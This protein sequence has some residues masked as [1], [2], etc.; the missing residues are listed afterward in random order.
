[1]KLADQLERLQALDSSRSFIVQAPAGSG[2]TEL[3]IQRFL[4]LLATVEKS[5]EEII[6]ITFTRKAASEM[7]ARVIT[8]LVGAE[9][10][11]ELKSEHERLTADL[12]Q[13]ALAQ[14]RRL[15]WNIIANPN[16]LRIQTIDSLCARLVSQMPILSQLTGGLVISDD[17]LALY[18]KAVRATLQSLDD[19]EFWSSALEQILLYLNNDFV[20]AER[21]LIDMLQRRDQWL[22]HIFGN[23]PREALEHALQDSIKE[24]LQKL[25]ICFSKME[26]NQELF[27]LLRF[28]ANNL[29]QTNP[30][31]AL[32]S[33]CD[34]VTFPALDADCL[35][36]WQAIANFLLTQSG[37]FRLKLTVKEGFPA[38]STAASEAD[39]S[40]FQNMK[41]RMQR[42]LEQCTEHEVLREELINTLDLPPAHYS[43]QQWQLISALVKLLPVLTAQ[44][45]L[46]FK[47]HKTVDH[48]EIALRALEA[49][50]HYDMPSDLALALDYQ[51]SHILI[52]EFQDTSLTQFRL[53]EKLT[54]GWEPYDQRT[55]FL[56]GDP[57][58][59]I[60][61][62]RKAE[63]GLF[64]QVQKIGVG[65]KKCDFLQL[66]VNFRSQD[67]IINWI[68]AS[69]KHI[70]P[71]QSNVATGAIHYS[72]SESFKNDE[73]IEA[74]V[75]IHPLLNP[76]EGAEANLV[77]KLIQNRL[78]SK[79][80]EKIAIL[81]QARSHLIEIIAALQ[82][83]NISY[84]AVEIDSLATSPICQDLL[85]LTRALTHLADRIAWLAILRAPWCGLTLADLL[86]IAV[87]PDD[88][89]IYDQLLQYE[90]L[91]LSAEGQSRLRKFMP[92]IKNS[93]QQ[94]QR[95]LLHQWLEATW[96]GLGGPACLI[97]EKE[98]INAEAFFNLLADCEQ[99]TGGVDINELTRRL[100]NLTAD[101][102]AI[103]DNP[104]EIMTIH[105]S[106]GLEFDTVIL[107]S[108]EKQTRSDSHQ[109]LLWQERTTLESEK[110]LIL[111]PIKNAQAE[112]IYDY[113]RKQE[114][115][116]ARH[117][118]ARLLYVAVTR[119]KNQLH[120]IASVAHENN[121]IKPPSNNSFLGLLW[122]QIEKLF[123]QQQEALPENVNTIIS[124][125]TEFPLR[126][127]SINW[128]HPIIKDWPEE[129]ANTISHANQPE[130][131]QHDHLKAT[132]IVIHRLL[133]QISKSSLT[134]W[135]EEKIDNSHKIIQFLLLKENIAK[136]FLN[137]S[138]DIT[139][140]ALKNS[141]ADIRG[142]WI[143]KDHE[144]AQ[145]EL[146]LSVIINNELKNITLDRTFIDN[147]IRWIIDYKTTSYNGSDV[148][149]FLHAEWLQHR[150]QLESYAAALRQNENHPIRLG[151]YFP[152][153]KAWYEWEFTPPCNM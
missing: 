144:Q 125:A 141:L 108:I 60:Y 119:S 127:L 95:G 122:P 51:I 8:A 142:R 104:I 44:L 120:L 110:Q 121:K 9:K 145:S 150:Q 33:C 52:D 70:F 102:P 137:L 105:K 40:L 109:L 71:A 21:L 50:G 25:Q 97:S 26:L 66:K 133:Y 107:P 39:K 129:D 18:Q 31:S 146:A 126:R 77:V 38:P 103:N 19:N 130:P 123:Y 136:P 92:V 153:L 96:L 84:R 76:A 11:T 62:F 90:I 15:G 149:S 140:Q 37:S 117:E 46:L 114:N 4:A 152:L 24:Q 99:F 80:Q 29:A 124:E 28:A 111:A 151:L 47:E 13:K 53:L 82:Q 59:S 85:A 116:K 55:L 83:S 115:V 20:K 7:R 73:F 58:Q 143:L 23:N 34:L 81:V 35:A 91:P 10:N 86:I 147:G 43:E 148:N 75:Q 45:T 113:L 100:Q 36:Q 79:P 63:V 69:F 42:L 6:A 54:A 14:D 128:Q 89:T 3:L 139:K 27:C 112:P 61:R 30:T 98:I 41:D 74:G 88:K 5:P 138:I 87:H 12:A 17:N 22:P 57:M 93:L 134:E 56:V 64:L 48:T 135:T 118:L 65:A 68:N 32:S 49:L 131:W 1:M 106:K 16:R 101:A 132:G 2:K 72:A 78:L 94:R 67:Q